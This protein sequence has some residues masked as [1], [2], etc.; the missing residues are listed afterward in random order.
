MF[1]QPGGLFWRFNTFRH[2]GHVEP[3]R[4]RQH[5]VEHR[6]RDRFR[7]N[8]V[9]KAAI[10]FKIIHRKTFQIN[11]RAV[12]CPEIVDGYLKPFVL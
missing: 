1:T 10:D 3:P 2:R 4:Q 11:Q 12:A 7:S 9:H 8:G 5:G 6:G